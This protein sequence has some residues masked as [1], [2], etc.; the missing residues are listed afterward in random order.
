V[1]GAPD[2]AAL[3]VD[4]QSTAARKSN[5]CCSNDMPRRKVRHSGIKHLKRLTFLPIETT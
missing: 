3:G 2:A 1:A 5:E 4:A